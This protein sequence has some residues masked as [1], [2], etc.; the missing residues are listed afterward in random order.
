MEERRDKERNP[1]RY[2]ELNIEIRQACNTAK[3]NWI[4]EQC[5]EVEEMQ[6]NHRIESMHRKIRGNWEEEGDKRECDQEQGW[7]TG[8]GDRGGSGALGG[9]CEGSF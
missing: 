5:K 3:E 6:R 9:V 1:Q 2:E 4:N 8:D 7:G